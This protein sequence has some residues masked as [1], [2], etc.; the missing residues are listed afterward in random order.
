MAEHGHMV[1]ERW[2]NGGV[3]MGIHRL[4]LELECGYRIRVEPLKLKENGLN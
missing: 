3:L 2:M 4:G 1:K